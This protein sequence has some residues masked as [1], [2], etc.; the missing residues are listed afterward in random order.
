MKL[1]IKEKVLS[2]MGGEAYIVYDVEQRYWLFLWN[3]VDRFKTLTQAEIFVNK[4]K[5]AMVYYE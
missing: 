1:R 5:N 4:L 2:T 3:Y